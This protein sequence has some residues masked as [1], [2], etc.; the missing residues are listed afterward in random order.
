MAV[1]IMRREL[2]AAALRQAAARSRDANAARRMLAIALV[3]DGHS[4]EDAAASCGMDRQTLR[5][6]VHRY[7]AEGLAGLANRRAPGPAPRLSAEQEAAVDRWVEQGPELARDGVVRWRCRGLR[8]RIGREFGVGLH[9]RTVGKLLAKLRF[10][11]LSVRPPHPQS[12][13]AAQAA[14]KGG[15]A[16]LVRAAVAGVAPG[17]PIE[18]WFMD[19][20]R[21]G[22]Q[23]T[24]TRVWAKRGARPRAVRDHR[25]TWAWLFGAVCPERRTGAAVV[26]P[27]VNIAAME[28]HLAAISE[29]VGPGAHAVL[30]LDGAGWHSSPRLRVPDNISLLPLP[31]YAPELNPVENVWEYLRQNWLSHRVWESYEA[32]VAACCDAWNALMRSPEQIASITTRSWAQVKL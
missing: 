4:R 26:M 32:I 16:E 14:F 12:D 1:E 19:E 27:E 24:L 31:R 8:E 23:G 21:V 6:W 15:F 10:R 11:R 20:A 18:V 13:P 2:S 29:R 30:V 5:D 3:L 22:Q 17:T 25:Y 28:A 7:N 9:E